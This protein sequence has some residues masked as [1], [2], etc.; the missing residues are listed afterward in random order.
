MLTS[1]ILLVIGLVVILASA[2][3]FTNGIEWLGRKLRLSEGAVGSVLAAVG[4]ALPETL[5]PMVA[6]LIR[7]GE[8]AKHVGVGAILGAPLMLSTLA[9]CVTGLAV[10]AYRKRRR[11]AQRLRINRQVLSRDLGFFLFLYPLA[12]AAGFFPP[13]HWRLGFCAALLLGYV[14]YLYLNFRETAAHHGE[15]APLRLHVIAGLTLLPREGEDRHAVRRR[16]QKLHAATPHLLVV[17]IQVGMALAG[18][19]V[20]AYVFVGAIQVLAKAVGIAPLVLS[21]VIT[22]IAT[23]LPEKFNSVLW[24]RQGKD[25]LALGN[26]TG[27]MVF[28]S[29]FPTAVG[30]TWTDWNLFHRRVGEWSPDGLIS[31]VIAL[32]AA[33][34]VLLSARRPQGPEGELRTS[35]NPWVLVGMVGLYA[36]F[37]AAAFVW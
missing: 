34:V 27:A 18:I 35:L 15:L 17:L 19:V 2:E 25:T 29:S 28:Q 23:E 1:I 13:S 33:L 22:P 30:I 6:V 4:T 20:G 21:L 31:V 7:G 11:G 8:S 36:V 24:V 14:Y 26:I 5:V 9:M 16:R 37:L 3:L 10:H 32:A 12:A